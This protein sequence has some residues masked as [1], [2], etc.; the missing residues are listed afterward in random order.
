MTNL[1]RVTKNL[2]LAAQFVFHNFRACIFR[3]LP[4][5]FLISVLTYIQSFLGGIFSEMTT[6]IS[7]FLYAMFA[8][9][10]HRYSVLESAKTLK[11]IPYQLG[12]RELMFGA[13]SAFSTLFITW[14]LGFLIQNFDQGTA[15]T[16]FALLLIPLLVTLVFVYPAIA[17][18][19]PL[20]I[21]YFLREGIILLPSFIVALLCVAICI[22][23]I[24]GGGYL[25][26][27][28]LTSIFTPLALKIILFVSIN[29]VLVP[30][31][32]AVTASSASFLYRDV[33]GLN[34]EE[35]V[36]NSQEQ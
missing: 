8:V 3:A 29:L 28:I 10:W 31:I 30:I 18:D 15:V 32:L 4:V 11:G 33:I 7:P 36:P 14:V 13:L 27:S 35:D 34:T 9:S 23:V 5:L 16:L 6:Y 12:T 19:Q 1:T 2:L 25:L 22:F 26:I 24:G 17:L 20:R 21:G